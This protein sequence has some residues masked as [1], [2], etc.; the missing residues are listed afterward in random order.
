MPPSQVKFSDEAV[1]F[2]ADIMKYENCAPAK[3][4]WNGIDV[5]REKG[6]LDLDNIE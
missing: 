3:I 5:G 6:M 1:L 2:D 4:A